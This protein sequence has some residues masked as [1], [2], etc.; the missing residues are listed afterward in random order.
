MIPIAQIPN[1][2]RGPRLGYMPPGAGQVRIPDLAGKVAQGQAIASRQG[3]GVRDI[4]GQIASTYGRSSQSKEAVLTSPNIN[5]PVARGLQNLAGGIQYAGNTIGQMGERARRR[6]E[7]RIK[8]ENELA[9]KQRAAQMKFMGAIWDSQNRQTQSAANRELAMY[10]EGFRQDIQRRPDI[11]PEQVAKEYQEGAGEIVKN[12]SEKMIGPE[13]GA[14]LQFQL[15]NIAT[16]NTVSVASFAGNTVLSRE[17]NQINANIGE[18]R[19]T[20]NIAAA[21]AEVDK[22][23]KLGHMGEEEARQTKNAT[24]RIAG[25]NDIEMVSASDPEKAEKKLAKYEEMGFPRDAVEKAQSTIA[26][27]KENL[28]VKTRSAIETGIEGGTIVTTDQLDALRQQDEFKYVTDSEWGML[29]SKLRK[30]PNLNPQHQSSVIGAV[31]KFDPSNFKDTATQDRAIADLRLQIDTSFEN[32]AYKTYLKELLKQK[33]DGDDVQ[34]NYKS[35]MRKDLELLRRDDGFGKYKKGDR[36]KESATSASMM[37]AEIK[38]GKWIDEAKRNGTLT[39]E[40]YQKEL[41][42]IVTEA[43]PNRGPGFITRV[44]GFLGSSERIEPR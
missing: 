34:V 30:Q 7:E 20:G 24:L 27:S 18:Y 11:N 31:E 28:R 14:A 6:S 36:E 37:K 22:A 12:Y 33:V 38:F 29:E 43:A 16:R 25:L 3:F 23:V 13:A 15:E 17:K 35:R 21:N 4:S 2:P 5:A 39:P 19:K 41:N 40:N 26:K 1:L 9:E 8:Y 44:L 10:T 42:R 32:P